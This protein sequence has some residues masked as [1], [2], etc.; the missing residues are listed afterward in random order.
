[1]PRTGSPVTRD[2]P[3][4][5]ITA[6]AI[7]AKVAELGRRIAHDYAGRQPFLLVGVL[8]GSFIFLADLA[9]Q[10]PIPHAVDFI[11]LS[12]Y[13]KGTTRTDEVRLMMDLRETIAGTHVLIVEDIVDTGHTLAYLVRLLGARQPASLETCTL[14]RK[15]T[16]HEVDVHLDYVG[17]DIPDRWVVG[18]GLDYADQ[19]RTLPYIGYVEPPC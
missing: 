11:A 7:A 1:M 10:I 16:R 15:P 5:L 8:K 6:D 4:V 18:Y 13:G 12:S 17:F 2:Q 14:V 3:Q 9:R 19:C